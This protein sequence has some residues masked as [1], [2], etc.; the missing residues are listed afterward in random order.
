M[1]GAEFELALAVLEV[2]ITVVTE[3]KN[4]LERYRGAL[5]SLDAVEIS[6]A[7]AGCKTEQFYSA[8]KSGEIPNRHHGPIARAV[9]ILTPKLDELGALLKQYSHSGGNLRSIDKAHW[10]A[11]GERRAK[12]VQAEIEDWSRNVFELVVV[13]LLAG[14]SRVESQTAPKEKHPVFIR[15]QISESLN[16]LPGVEATLSMKGA[17]ATVLANR[18]YFHSRKFYD[19]E[20]EIRNP[21]LSSFEDYDDESSN[22]IING[23]KVL[24]EHVYLNDSS[25]ITD[26]T[27][28][29][30]VGD[31]A[32]ILSH[33]DPEICYIPTCKGFFKDSIENRYSLVFSG[34][35]RFRGVKYTLTPYSLSSVISLVR[36]PEPHKHTSPEIELINCLHDLESRTKLAIQL[37]HALS[38]IHAIGWVHKGFQSSKVLLSV[39]ENN[40]V[41]PLVVGFHSSRPAD[42]RTSG[43]QEY[44]DY[45]YRHPDRWQTEGNPTFRRRYDVYSLAVVLLE[46]GTGRLI[47][48]MIPPHSRKKRFLMD[49]NARKRAAE[50]VVDLFISEARR[51]KMKQGKAY[52]DNLEAGFR[53]TGILQQDLGD[54]GDDDDSDSDLC[55]NLLS[56]W[57][58]ELSSTQF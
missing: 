8:L 7:L 13:T 23:E 20:L 3:I 42:L 1:S 33:S 47:H 26:A 34:T 45:L 21:T 16:K 4:F 22:A 12:K 15:G 17:V 39:D 50:E 25:P 53:Y 37:I 32:H 43:R 56:R 31:L 9:E 28:R 44:E 40:N 27:V 46:L 30:G 49:A 24:L 18:P 41:I 5:K 11:F 2:S 54:K 6:V 35:F 48:E 52:A 58:T 57:V 55:R 29:K 38:Y 19:E 51:L 10:A 36:K 14:G